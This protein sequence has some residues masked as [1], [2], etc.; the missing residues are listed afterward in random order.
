[1]KA[2]A[3]LKFLDK[4]KKQQEFP[5][6]AY[7]KAHSK[8]QQEFLNCV[9]HTI[10][11]WGGKR[12]GKSLGG[13]SRVI[14]ADQQFWDGPRIVLAGANL[15][16]IKSLYWNPL[17]LASQYFDLGWEFRAG[18][19]M[20]NTKKRQIVFRSLRDMAN[21]DKDT[22][23]QVCL[24]QVEEAH[25]IRSHIFDYWVK[26]IIR[27]NFL[28]VHGA[29]LI[30]ICNPPVFPLPLFK[31]DFYNNP[32]VVK[33]HTHAEDNP[34]IPKK[35]LEDYKKQ[36][37]KVL[38]YS[39]VEEASKNSNEFRRNIYG[40]WV[41]DKGR[42]IFSK[43]RVQYFEET[44]MEGIEHVIGAD[45]GG[46][47]SHHAITVICYSK[48]E[49]K[50]WVV[51]EKEIPTGEGYD[52]I[53]S[54]ATNIK[55]AYEKYKAHHVSLDTGGVGSTIASTLQYKYGVPSVTPAIKI[56]KMAHLEEMRAEINRGRLL[57]RRDSPFVNEMDQ[58]IYT[59]DRSGVDDLNG[60][61]SDLMD[62]LLYAM[63]FVFNA[64]P[65][66]RPK[67]LSYKEKRI[68]EIMANNRRGRTKI[69]Y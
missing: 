69:G 43:D 9:H 46:G 14:V 64:W 15:E 28:N 26:N 67:E 18:D 63:R 59:E 36:E 65:Q 41:E 8:K 40:E 10:M 49:R 4:I 50:A 17:F 21:A 31:R 56:E 55:W 20:I 16:K 13:A 39:S 42:L 37:A 60:I 44:D 29:S 54:L 62:S 48:F 51:Y 27:V 66:E 5:V 6:E 23:F 52:D 35:V 22:G 53:E 25:T 19:N 1:M 34:S 68:R 47:R 3:I 24:A 58:I 38:G 57:F 30:V 32:E 7:I 2:E 33:I 45:I 11:Y 12:S 61:H